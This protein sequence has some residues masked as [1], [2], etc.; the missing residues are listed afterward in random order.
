MTEGFLVGLG[1]GNLT[2]GPDSA[3][4]QVMAQSAGV[5]DVLNQYYMLG[6]TNGLYSFGGVGYA[7]AGANPVAQFM[8]SF[9][10]SI[11]GGVLSLTTTTSFKSLTFDM[12]PQWQRSSFAPMGNTHQTYQIS[13]T[14]H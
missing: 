2:F 13:V 3:T 1:P 12:G 14:C 10:W 9:R 11:S 5:Q 4:S 6:R 7:Q 8:G